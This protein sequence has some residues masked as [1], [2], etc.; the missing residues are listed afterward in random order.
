[1]QPPTFQ[2]PPS[3]TP[4]PKKERSALLT[5]MLALRGVMDLAVVGLGVIAY[6]A[7]G[8]QS[9]VTI[10]RERA[11]H[12]ANILLVGIVIAFVELMGVIGTFSYKKWGVYILLGFAGLNI[13]ANF[14]AGNTVAAYVALGTTAII[15]VTLYPRW[16]DYD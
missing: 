10:P 14:S 2:F 8:A 12:A 13:M 6:T 11:Q 15:G 4:K 5:G 1:M 7:L 3:L 9:D 16:S